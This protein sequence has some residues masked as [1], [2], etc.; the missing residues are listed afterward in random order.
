MP[1]QTQAAPLLLSRLIPLHAGDLRTDGSFVI[2]SEPNSG[3]PPQ[4]YGLYAVALPNA[5]PMRISANVHTSA[6]GPGN[7]D[8]SNGVVVWIEGTGTQRELRAHNLREAST[9]TVASGE[10]NFPSINGTTVTWW[11]D[12]YVRDEETARKLATL[13]SRDIATM[14]SPRVLAQ[15]SKLTYGFGPSYTGDGWI[16]YAKA[17]GAAKVQAC[18]VLEVVPITGGTP[19][20]ISGLALARRSS[21]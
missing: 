9:L 21:T 1:Q 3:T 19:A 18:W 7:V 2:W 13:M 20:K 17:T 15:T 5:E 6:N 12:Y 16:A 8:I 4:P 11:E 14:A 10:I